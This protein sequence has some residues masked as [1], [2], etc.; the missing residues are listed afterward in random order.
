MRSIGSTALR[1]KI[2]HSMPSTTSLKAASH[3]AKD[4]TKSAI[5]LRA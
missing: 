3:K 5:G 4:T 1:P 2:G